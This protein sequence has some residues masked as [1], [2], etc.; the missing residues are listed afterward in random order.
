MGADEPPWYSS[1]PARAP[2]AWI[3]SAVSPSARASA[4]SQMSAA[5][6]GVSSVSAAIGAYSTQTPPQP[7]SALMARNA[8]WVLGLTDPNP[9]ACGTW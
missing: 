8:A 9:L 3:A 7:P 1:S 4:S 5:I 2:C 6:A